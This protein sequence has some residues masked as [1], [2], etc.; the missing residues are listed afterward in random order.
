MSLAGLHDAI[1]L[2][3][4]KMNV[5]KKKKRR[6]KMPYVLVSL[7]C[8]LN[9]QTAIT[10]KTLSSTSVYF[11]CHI[12]SASIIFTS[13]LN[14]MISKLKWQQ[15]F[16]VLAEGPQDRKLKLKLLHHI[17]SVKTYWGEGNLLFAYICK[18]DKAKIMLTCT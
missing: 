12:Q 9:I 10:K 15:L 6:L 5:K 14:H 13:K 16:S 3:N 2:S 7:D 18:M 17:M 11:H 8:L 1:R 4:F